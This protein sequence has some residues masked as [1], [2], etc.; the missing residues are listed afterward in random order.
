MPNVISRNHDAAAHAELLALRDAARV[1]K[2]WRLRDC[3]LYSTLEPCPMCLAAAQ[4]FRVEQIVYGAPD[5]RLGAHVTFM[6]LLDDYQHPYHTIQSVVP[7][8][9]DDESAGMLRDFFRSRRKEQEELKQKLKQHGEQQSRENQS[10]R[11]GLRTMIRSTCSIVTKKLG[12]L[13]SLL[14]KRVARWIIKIK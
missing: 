1:L 13:P 14:W 3:V 5:T 10:I 9:L 12:A 4:A 8:V 6:K 11:P 2:N 7:G